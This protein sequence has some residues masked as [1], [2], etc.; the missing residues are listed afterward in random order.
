MN[1]TTNRSQQIAAKLLEI[2][3]VFLRPDDLF[4][5]ASGIKSPIY[6]DNRVSLSFPETRNLIKNSFV[7]LIR[8]NYS[9]LDAVAGVATAG[10]PH[11]SLIA[12][13]MDLPM[14]YV[15]SSS[16]GH[17]R[18]NQIEGKL[19][20]GSKVVV[21]EDLISTGGS[22]LKAVEALREA[23]IEV[24]GLVAIFTYNLQKSVDAFKEANVDYQTLSDYD[25]L[26]DYALQS[27]QIQES[28]LKVLQE[29][30]AQF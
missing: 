15:R 26:V 9:G 12:D 13:A 19:E 2:G 5:W 29:F 1:N 7:D 24:L 21:V 28:D 4:T 8:E 17:G 3:A 30:K 11:A 23:G 14:I 10:I 20:A 16:K 22:S 25:T 18:T 6:C 27:G